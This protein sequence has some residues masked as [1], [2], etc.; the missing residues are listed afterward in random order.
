[1]RLINIGSG[2]PSTDRSDGVGMPTDGAPKR[3]KKNQRAIGLVQCGKCPLSDLLREAERMDVGGIVIANTN[4]CG[5]PTK[6]FLESAT[7]TRVPVAFIAS[8]AAGEIQTMLEQII[9]LQSAAQP[10]RPEDTGRHDAFIYLSIHD[11]GLDHEKHVVGRILAS[12]HILLAMMAGISL[13]VYLSLACSFGSLRY[14]P[15]ELAPGIFGA[16]AEPVDKEVLEK[17]PLVPVEWDVPRG[18]DEEARC[19]TPT[20][21][22]GPAHRSL[23]RQLAGIIARSG[24]SS[25]SFRDEQ[26]CAICLDHYVHNESLRLLPCKHAFHRRCIDAWLLSDDITAH[27]PI[28]K[29]DITEGLELLDKHGY[30]DVLDLMQGNSCNARC[31]PVKTTSALPVYVYEA[32]CDRISQYYRE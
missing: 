29:S 24:D 28:C 10:Q 25:Y 15:R 20:A 31:P 21:D 27:C 4:E 12:T 8:K 11:S 5:R 2:C 32:I 14:I 17:L 18:S 7:N 19:E 9:A 23:L 3:H 13:A 22:L 1:G 6:E 30:G 26:R 16:R